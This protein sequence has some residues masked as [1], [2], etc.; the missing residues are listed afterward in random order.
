M[1]PMLISYNF[2]EEYDEIIMFCIK[3]KYGLCKKKSEAFNCYYNKNTD[4]ASF[5][6]T[7]QP[8]TLKFFDLGMTVQRFVRSNVKGYIC[9][10]ATS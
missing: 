3:V 9:E 6:S 10:E 7:G 4:I 2:I 1:K 8:I 5:S